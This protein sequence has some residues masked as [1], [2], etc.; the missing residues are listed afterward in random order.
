MDT[1]KLDD[2]VD[3][4]DTNY[5]TAKVFG[6]I[7][8]IGIVE[9]RKDVRQKEK[10]FEQC[11]IEFYLEYGNNTDRA[12]G[13]YYDKLIHGYKIL[14]RQIMKLPP[15]YLGDSNTRQLCYF[16]TYLIDY[17]L[18]AIK[19][20]S[21]I[22]KTNYIQ[23]IQDKRKIDGF[24]NDTNQQNEPLNKNRACSMHDADLQKETK[25]LSCAKRVYYATN[26][27]N[28]KLRR[29]YNYLIDNGHLEADTPLPDF[30]Y[31]F[32]GKGKKAN[33][34]LK[35]IKKYRSKVNLAFFLI[36]VTGGDRSEECW[37]KAE[38]VFGETGLAQSY[39]QAPETS[40]SQR[41]ISRE[42]EKL[43]K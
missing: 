39:N 32:T 3:M 24:I 26:H 6:I 2:F 23:D 34:R 13:I 10:A 11:V 19:Y 1:S 43:L 20:I 18:K 14:Y 15:L 33:N 42:V 30:L 17:S 38:I 36:A 21:K 9:Y 22:L 8:R 27:T 41:K 31:Y 12:L 28:K 16:Y 29:V 40:T 37:K 5:H 7:N 25:V 4:V 35:W